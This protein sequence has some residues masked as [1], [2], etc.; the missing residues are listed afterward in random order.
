M[1]LAVLVPAICKILTTVDP[2]DH[3]SRS[4]AG[5][6]IFIGGFLGPRPSAAAGSMLPSLCP[7]ARAEIIDS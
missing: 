2:L 6:K 5:V 7:A 3:R 1:G 4:F